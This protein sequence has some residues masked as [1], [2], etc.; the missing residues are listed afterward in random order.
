MARPQAAA[1]SAAKRP[2]EDMGEAEPLQAQPIPRQGG[3]KVTGIATTQEVREQRQGL[4]PAP[5]S[6]TRRASHAGAAGADRTQCSQ[7]PPAALASVQRRPADLS[8]TVPRYRGGDTRSAAG[9]ARL[10]AAIAARQ[11]ED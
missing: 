6:A 9:V 11:G 2:G 4:A 5:A 7:P 1:R 8:K 3:G 10:G